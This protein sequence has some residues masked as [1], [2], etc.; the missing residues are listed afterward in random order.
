MAGRATRR[1]YP[2][3]VMETSRSDDA[4]QGLFAQCLGLLQ[5]SRFGITTQLRGIPRCTQ[6]GDT[7]IGKIHAHPVGL[8]DGNDIHAVGEKL[9]LQTRIVYEARK[10]AL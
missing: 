10:Q 3:P 4:P 8:V 1:A 2:T 7:P 5:S 9:L 6:V